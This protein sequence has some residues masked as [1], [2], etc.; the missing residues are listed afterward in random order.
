MLHTIWNVIYTS[1]FQKA[2][3]SLSAILVT[4]IAEIKSPLAFN[5]VAMDQPKFQ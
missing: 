5:K 3:F 2:T 4:N 1:T